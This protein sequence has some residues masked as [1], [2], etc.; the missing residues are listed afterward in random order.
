MTLE[1]IRK[2]IDALDDQ[3]IDLL[4]RRMTLVEEVIIAK[5][6]ENKDV[7]DSGRESFI[8][9][10]IKKRTEDP[11]YM[12][13]VQAIYKEIMKHSREYQEKNRIK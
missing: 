3:M 2:E 8:L 4:I 12:S 1:K 5:A 10:K 9:E 6:E 7:Y 11:Q 13:T